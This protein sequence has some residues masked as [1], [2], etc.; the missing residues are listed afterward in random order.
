MSTLLEFRERIMIHL[1]E[2]GFDANLHIRDFYS[3]SPS[4]KSTYPNVLVEL[5]RNGLSNFNTSSQVS[6]ASILN[7]EAC[8]KA[9]RSVRRWG[10]VGLLLK[11]LQKIGATY[12]MTTEQGETEQHILRLT[13]YDILPAAAL[14]PII[15]G[16]RNIDPYHRY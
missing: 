5:I 3:W 15:D 11:L 2:R 12:K 10:K 6:L 1:S 14:H 13:K 4:T 16:V 9:N 8:A 7:F